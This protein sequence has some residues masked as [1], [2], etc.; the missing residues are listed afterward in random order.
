M[1]GKD[2]FEQA[3]DWIV[4]LDSGSLRASDRAEFVRWLNRKPEH[5]AAYEEMSQLWARMDT[6]GSASQGQFAAA[7]RPVSRLDVPWYYSFRGALA[8]SLAV[9]FLMSVMVVVMEPGVGFRDVRHFVTAIGQTHRLVAPDGSIIQMGGR[10]AIALEYSLGRRLVRFEH[11][12]IT[13][14]AAHNPKRPFTIAA[15]RHV[16]QA[17][18]T[19]FSVRYDDS[20][21][22]VRV[23]DGKVS[24]SSNDA[25]T[26]QALYR[27]TARASSAVVLNPGQSLLYGLETHRIEVT[28][29]GA[30]TDFKVK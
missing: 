16:I 11:G 5:A 29:E 2:L 24:F 27:H 9:I 15:G 12:E 19:E 6:L 4:R 17:L 14:K 26:R 23:F 13:I 18:G 1:I 21:I 30:G 8:A 20:R 22:E 3:S 10:T 28:D 25:R 7:A